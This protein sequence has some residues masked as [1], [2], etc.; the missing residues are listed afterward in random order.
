MISN[1]PLHQTR[2]KRALV[3]GSI[4]QSLIMVSKAARKSANCIFIFLMLHI[5]SWGESTLS[6][7]LLTAEEATQLVIKAMP[8]RMAKLPGLSVDVGIP[9]R[10]FRDV[11]F[12]DILWR[13]PA[14]GSGVAGHFSVYLQT[15]DVCDPIDW[16]VITSSKLMRLQKEMRK[17]IGLKDAKYQEIRKRGPC[18]GKEFS[19]PAK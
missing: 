18:Y 19:G 5:F 11:I 10:D 1:N 3:S 8:K 13:N 16:T 6:T 14:P 15:G 9:D 7:R 12:F 2:K 17:R 4:R